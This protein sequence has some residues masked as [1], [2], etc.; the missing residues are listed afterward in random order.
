ML[1]NR[2]ANFKATEKD[3][4]M[5]NVEE[6]NFVKLYTAP[7]KKFDMNF[8]FKDEEDKEASSFSFKNDLLSKNEYNFLKNKMNVQQQWYWMIQYQTKIKYELNI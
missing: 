4:E 6:Q 8:H 7:L 3:E 2:T 1:S 5:S